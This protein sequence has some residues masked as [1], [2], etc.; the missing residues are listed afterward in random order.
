MNK[1][2][3]IAVVLVAVL[4]LGGTLVFA[5]VNEDGSWVNPFSN[6]L[7]S[8][9][10]DGTITQQEADIFSKVMEAIKG[11]INKDKG[12]QSDGSHKRRH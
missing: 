8:K 4:A 6:I 1:K 10:E 3:I 2:I 12:K 7:S 5:A 11:D 9:I